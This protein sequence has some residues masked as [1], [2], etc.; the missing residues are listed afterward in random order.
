MLL[1]RVRLENVLSYGPSGL[2]LELEPLN[3]LIGPNGS[4]KS[5]LIEVI[6]LLHAAPDS[7]HQTILDG[8]GV[9]NWLWRGEPRETFAQIEAFIPYTATIQLSYKL[10]FREANQRFQIHSEIICDD[11][12]P[13]SHPYV[14]SNGGIADL[15]PEG[16][17]DSQVLSKIK[18]M[19]VDQDKSVLSQVKAHTDYPELTTIAKQLQQIRLYRQWEFGRQAQLRKTSTGRS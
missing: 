2:D 10:C 11:G 12:V 5:N 18:R 8:G 7:L 13:N 17:R 3:V 16:S 15:L 19:P 14:D 4:G 1:K 9:S 6:G